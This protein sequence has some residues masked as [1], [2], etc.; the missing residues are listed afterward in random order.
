MSSA[1]KK[2][3]GYD[4]I[5][6]SFFIGLTIVFTNYAGDS[7]LTKVSTNDLTVTSKD[8]SEPSKSTDSKVKGT[9]SDFLSFAA[10]AGWNSERVAKESALRGL[11]G[12]QSVM[13]YIRVL[14]ISEENQQSKK[15]KEEAVIFMLNSER[16]SWTPIRAMEEAAKHNLMSN[17]YIVNY[18]TLLV[19]EQREKPNPRTQEKDLKL[20]IKKIENDSLTS[21]KK[22]N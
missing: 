18:L 6:K 5:K 12:E 14:A 19:K 20:P 4:M 15:I 8:K 9:I 17:E 2:I 1:H 7:D 3:K 13:N 16:N 11:M 21:S 22:S 10:H